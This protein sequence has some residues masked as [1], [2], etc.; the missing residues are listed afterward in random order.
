MLENA[1]QCE[2]LLFS[3]KKTKHCVSLIKWTFLQLLQMPLTVMNIQEL[4][5]RLMKASKT[6]LKD[7]GIF[8]NIVYCCYN[9]IHFVIPLIIN[10]F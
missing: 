8:H 10:V 3:I 1:N 6:T 9:V 5:F 4:W 7:E 2:Y